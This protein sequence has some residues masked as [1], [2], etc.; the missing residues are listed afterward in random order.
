MLPAD[1]EISTDPA[2][3]DIDMVHA[4]LRESYWGQGRSRD[5]VE[6]S[7]ANS[8]CFGAYAGSRQV[9]FGR[10]VTDRAL[11]AYLADVFVLPEFRGR[12]ISKALVRA[13]IEHPDLSGLKMMFLRTRDAHGLYAQFGFTAVPRP[14]EMMIRLQP[15]GSI[16][17]RVCAEP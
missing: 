15:V 10:V 14:E 7:I 17:S 8:I 4:F 6:R 1:L 5:V 12:G 13:M 11:F 3:L 16:T 2:R 9:A